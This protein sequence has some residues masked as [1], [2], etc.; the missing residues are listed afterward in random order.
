VPHSRSPARAAAVFG[1]AQPVNGSNTIDEATPPKA[2]GLKT[3]TGPRRPRKDPVNSTKSVRVDVASTAPGA[4]R[5]RHPSAPDLPVRG[6]PTMSSMS[7]RGAHTRNPPTRA[8]GVANSN[9]DTRDR[10]RGLIASVVGFSTVIRRRAHRGPE[11]RR[12]THR[13]A[14]PPR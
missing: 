1:S 9:V 6:P 12:T 13:D 5:I 7:S 14:S 2:D 10:V 11:C 3:D 4:S 8:T